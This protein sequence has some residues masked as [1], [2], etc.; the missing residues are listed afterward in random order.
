[1]ELTLKSFTLLIAIVL[2]GL[3]AGFF[4]AWQVSVI[5]GTKKVIDITYMESMQSINK[6]ILNPA[7][8][9]IFMGSPL[10]LIISTIQQ[11]NSRQT[12]WFLL[13][14]TIIYLVGTFGV[15]AF[16]NV[17]LND[18]L[19]ALNLKELSSREQSSFR[20]D[21]E[22]KWNRLH[23]IRTVFAVLSF[24]LAFLSTFP[25]FKSI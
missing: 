21:Y 10:L 7:F 11:Y 20:Q 12:F 17:P 15:T 8:Y 13:A 2:T 14:A 16:G 1:M 5:P 4:Y 25:L 24:V 19:E 9:L 23:L 18:A 3:S 6:E 22:Q